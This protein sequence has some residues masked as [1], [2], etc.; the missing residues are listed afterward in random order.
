MK[1]GALYLAVGMALTAPAMAQSA[2]SEADPPARE[3]AGFGPADIVVT[4]QKRAENIQN[5]PISII[6]VSGETLENA[7]IRSALDLPRI[8][9]NMVTSRGPQTASTRLSVRGLG[10]SGNSAVEP[11]V[12]VFIDGFYI[13]RPGSVFGTFLDIDSVEVLRGPQGT[14]FGRN[15]AVGALNLR[16]AMPAD[17]L[18]GGLN[19]EGGT[20]ERY[21]ADGYV[22]IPITDSI[23]TRTAAVIERFGGY[24]HNDHDGKRVGSVNTFAIRETI[25][26]D[27]SPNLT[28]VLR[29]DYTRL[30]GDGQALYELLPNTL[31][32]A[33]KARLD[34]VMGAGN[35]DLKPF[36]FHGNQRLNSGLSDRNLGFSS[37]LS[38]SVGND[39]TLRLLNSYRNWRN[40]QSVGDLSFLP[41]AILSRD[42]A[43]DNQ[44]HS[45]E[46]Q[47]ISP[48]DQLLDG[49][50]DFVAGLYYQREIYDINGLENIGKDYCNLAVPVPNRP[51]CLITPFDAAGEYHL[52]QRGRSIAGYG[53]ASV[54]I[55][56]ELILTLGGR[57]TDDR[58][59]GRFVQTVSNPYFGIRAPEDTPLHF[60]DNRFTYRINLAYNPT[61][62]T[63]LFATYST[64]YKSGGFNSGAGATVLSSAQRTFAPETIK[65][66]EAG[67]KTRFFDRM[68][69]LNGTLY[70]MDVS[71]YQDRQ[72]DSSG[73]AA[74]RN[75]GEVRQQGFELDGSI[76]PV[77]QLTLSGAVA[78]LDSEFLDY[79]GAP[80][81]PAFGGIQDLSGQRANYS[82]RWSG[83]ASAEWSDTIGTSGW[84]WSLRSDLSFTSD[85]N[86]SQVTDGN[87]DT[88]QKGYALLGARFTVFAPDDKLSFSV[89][90]QNLTDK[91]YCSLAVYQVLD[92]PLGLRNMSTGSTLVRCIAG[93]PRTIGVSA[94][95]RF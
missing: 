37:D 29:G 31:T 23:R 5:V 67:F 25:E 21:K 7:G 13:P 41:L 71:G 83:T 88:I 12:G 42:E 32:A 2:G 55:V 51:T 57:Y 56:P 9:P 22:N 50:L 79:A 95:L 85:V 72:I 53:Q 54:K 89:F 35:Y 47:I 34:M 91:G 10:A 65:N 52:A 39:F 40:R 17:T 69:T 33:G 58:K 19:L 81:L 45:H 6:A 66:Y 28:W 36:D 82:P 80:G 43:F 76:R 87:P 78:Y 86:L 16:T 1:N 94:S 62:E 70:R 49:R 30:T 18:S 59:S 93:P 73:V 84:N 38:W 3:S 27:L 4:A 63:M 8:V 75:V 60:S 24:Y 15:T 90:G 61:S 46:L 68:V 92:G 74:V 11:S 77:H 48:K 44:S 26:A 14:L 20:G 64:G